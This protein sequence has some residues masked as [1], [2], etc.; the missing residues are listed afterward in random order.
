MVEGSPLR[1]RRFTAL[2]DDQKGDSNSETQL[3]AR[4][5]SIGIFREIIST[6]IE[7]DIPV[8]RSFVN[9]LDDLLASYLGV[10][11]SVVTKTLSQPIAVA[12]PQFCKIATDASGIP[13]LKD[14]FP[15]GI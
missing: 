1:V 8:P 13:F 3:R 2:P 11:V 6:D 5:A 15:A 4:V 10:G 14:S 7:S 9:A 12:L